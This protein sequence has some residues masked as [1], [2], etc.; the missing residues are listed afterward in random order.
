VRTSY[1]KVRLRRLALPIAGALGAAAAV[2]PG[3]VAGSA[4]TSASFTAYDYG[5]MANGSAARTRVTIARGSTVTFA[6]PSGRSEHNADFFGT[7]PKPSGC[8]QTAGPSSGGVPPLPRQPTSA[9]W[10]GTCTFNAP[11]TYTFHCDL[12]HFMTAT[13]VVQ[14]T[15]GPPLA[16]RPSRA[17]SIRRHQ[18]GTAVRGVVRLSNAATGGRLEVDLRTSAKALG[19]HGRRPVRVGRL[20]RTR[21][22]PGTVRFAAR[23]DPAAKRAQRT[24]GSLALTVEAIVTPPGFGPTSVTRRV[25][26]RP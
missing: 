24:A 13:I 6:Y 19:R 8:T 7:G 14:G 21:L 5:W 16:G 12:H 23:L 20:I 17:V 10:S 15:G 9:G 4:P 2:V 11:G 3:A 22:K 18:R 26:L 1:P 25:R